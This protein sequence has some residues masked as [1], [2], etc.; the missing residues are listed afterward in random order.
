[1]FELQQ[2]PAYWWPVPVPFAKDGGGWD[3]RE[4]QIQFKRMDTDQYAEFMAEVGRER[5]GDRE[6]CRRIVL[7][8]RAVVATPGG[9]EV[10]FTPENLAALLRLPNVAGSIVREWMDSFGKAAEKNW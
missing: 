4:L 1:M 2:S 5:I 8:W 10:P 9:P 6:V 7:G 3:R